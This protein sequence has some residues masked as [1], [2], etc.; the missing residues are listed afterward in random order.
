VAVRR[1]PRCARAL[2]LLAAACVLLPARAAPAA[3]P[4]AAPPLPTATARS[5]AS[6]A[7]AAPS[8]SAADALG[9]LRAFLQGTRTLA[10]DFEQHGNDARPA[11]V[12]AGTPGAAAGPAPPAR[13]VRGRLELARPD[14]F[15]WQT[16]APFE[17]TIVADGRELW[18]YDRDLNQVTVRAQAAAL[19]QSPAALLASPS[20]AELER[21]F[22]L[23]DLGPGADGLAWVEARPKAADSLYASVA[24]GF[25]DGLP[26]RIELR[27]Q[28]GRSA[29]ITLS[30]IRRNAA[31]DP[32]SL[33]F[34]APPGADLIRQ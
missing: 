10:A 32:A 12:P 14:R 22:T 19:A 2:L 21:H 5:A 31:L 24:L 8:A 15:R 18:T 28:F 4:A 20:A 11:P 26:E 6:A 34:A 30:N 9:Q 13:V 29:R 7:S 17:Q 33:R 1:G 25:R 16:G 3:A 23:K 27:D